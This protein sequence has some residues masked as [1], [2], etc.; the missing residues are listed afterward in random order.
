MS[1]FHNPDDRGYTVSDLA[2]RYRV[3]ECKVRTWITRGDIR[4]INTSA[5]GVSRPRYV[6]PSDALSEFEAKRSP[7]V[8]PKP[9]RKR[10]VETKDWFPDL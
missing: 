8:P 2:K 6:V 9:R 10:R 4:A 7:A 5:P 3:S 1:A